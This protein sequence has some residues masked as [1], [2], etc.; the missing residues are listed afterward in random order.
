MR[1]EGGGVSLPM[2]TAVPI[3]R[4]GTQVKFRDL[5]SYL[6]YDYQGIHKY[7]YLYAFKKTNKS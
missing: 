6:T 5:T 1:G 4:H 3:T 2:R 7:R